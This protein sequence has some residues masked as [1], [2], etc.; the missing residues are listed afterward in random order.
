MTIFNL[1]NDTSNTSHVQSR[2][3]SST[4]K[5]N[6]EINSRNTSVV[7]E[8]TSQISHT[9]KPTS[10]LSHTHTH[11][12]VS[13]T[14][15]KQK[16][17]CLG[18][19]LV[20]KNI[21]NNFSQRS[22]GVQVLQKLVN[23]HVRSKSIMCMPS[24]TDKSCQSEIKIV[25]RMCSP[26]KSLLKTSVTANSNTF[27]SAVASC[28]TKSSSSE[29]Q[30]SSHSV[31]KCSSSCSEER[32]END[33]NMKESALNITR[34]FISIDAKKYIGIGN[35]WL[36]IIDLLHSSTKCNIDDI[37]LILMKIRTNDTF[38]WS[39]DQFGLSTSQTSRVFN[40]TVK[41]L[42]H[43]LKT[44]VYCPDPSSI[45]MNLPVTFRAYYS[46]VCAIFDA[47]EIEIEKPSNPVQEALT[48]SEYKKCN[49]LKYLIVCTPDGFIT[50][51]F[52]GYGGRISDILLFEES[53]VIWIFYQKNVGLWLTEDLN[54]YK[55]F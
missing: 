6:S 32:K 20:S 24:T 50:F 38:S 25:N 9:Y 42:A 7:I 44:L 17:L 27:S 2:Y 46:H 5:V 41:P 31:Y 36:W 45:K 33:K 54:K 8:S 3:I 16:V 15:D 28:S 52:S 29:Y 53:K 4:N 10:N 34:Y 12:S 35:E 18:E 40:K 47:F 26:I 55:Q 49:T 19:S 37:K 22:F 48:W 21:K 13:K 51:I 39:R 43:Y 1:Q 30:N 11:L 23:P 14:K